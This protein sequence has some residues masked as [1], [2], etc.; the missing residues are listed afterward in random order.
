ME[1]NKLSLI[2]SIPL[3]GPIWAESILTG[4]ALIDALN[5]IN[6]RRELQRKDEPSVIDQLEP[7]SKETAK[8][9]DFSKAA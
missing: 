9:E 8:H 6:L 2:E 5:L 1:D 4:V 3:V 7:E